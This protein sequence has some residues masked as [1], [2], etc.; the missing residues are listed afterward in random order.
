[1]SGHTVAGVDW[2]GGDW[3][4]V[5]TDGDEIG[6]YVREDV[7]ALWESVADFDRVLIDVPIGL[8]DTEGTLEKREETD[9]VARTVAGR[10]SSVFPVPSRGACEAANDGADYETVADRNREDLEKGLSRQSYYIAAGIGDVDALLRRTESAKE[11]LMESHPEVCF[12]GLLDRQL[13]HSKTTAQGVGERLEALEGHLD[14]P[15]AVLGRICRELVDEPADV[16]VDDVVDALGL[17]V[18]AS[19]PENELRSLPEG[20]RYDDSEGIPIRMVYW[21]EEPLE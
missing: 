8:P 18:V 14:D 19:R 20:E 5:V 16:T 12:R 2:A 11:T 21:S 13:K 7:D 15:G 4:A 10:S 3:L 1:M 6:W 9:S 17:C